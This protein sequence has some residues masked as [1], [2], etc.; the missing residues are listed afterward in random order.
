MASPASPAA[1]IGWE[2]RLHH[3]WGLIA[4]A[5]YL[6]TL[7]TIKLALVVHGQALHF[8][9]AVSFALAVVVPLAATFTYLLVVFTYGFS[10]D[11][12]GRPSIYPTRMFTL[13]VSTA[14]LAG[15]PML[16]GTAA[17]AILWIAN[18]LLV[19]WPASLDVPVLWPALLAAALV[20]WTQALVWMPYGLPGLRVIVTVLWLVVIDTV[21]ILA[22]YFQVREP[23]ML[24]ILTP[25]FPLAYF[26]ARFAVSRARRNTV[27]DWRGMFA[28][29]GRRVSV[30][31][32]RRRRDRF[33]SPARA[34]AWFEWRR[35]G[36]SLPSW[37]GIL[38]PF[39]LFL[40]F[41]A[42]G[43][44]AIVFTILG[45]A[46][47]T[48]PLMAA[49]VAPAVRRS[50]A[51]PGNSYGVTPFLATRP[52]SNAALIAAKLKMA[53]WSTLAA[54]LLV[55][56]AIPTALLLSDTWPTVIDEGRRAIEFMGAPR[57]IVLLLI[58]LLGFMASTW[59]QLVQALYVGLTGRDWFVKSSVFLT[60]VF[61][62]ALG[63]VADWIIGRSHVQAA[64]WDAIPWILAVLVCLK[65]GV[66]TWV[67]VRLYEDR[68]LGDRT[69]VIGAALW[70]VAVLALYGVFAWFV[71]SPFFP[72]YVLALLAILAIPL[73]RTSAA[74][75]VLAWNRHR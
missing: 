55:L 65:M 61:F 9:S 66:A 64:L 42:R 75:L 38:L 4:F 45:A 62:S 16:Y 49:F 18:R 30:G 14:A 12:A 19:V 68:L 60:L 5:A 8:H 53:M 21:V 10:G 44:P 13:P 24:A 70:C 47:L 67:A 34:Q 74:P 36:R 7:A 73:A 39:E 32:R 46:L 51:N 15:W 27:P 72:H 71:S 35:Y 33:P 56:I 41:D 48:P 28:S 50:S 1:A 40:L 63:P 31:E 43:A 22:L 23:V 58:I 11:L 2:F 52:L 25:Q 3:R 29:L 54:W 26:A 59:K 20:A 17:A 57:V 37:V 69:L 6:T